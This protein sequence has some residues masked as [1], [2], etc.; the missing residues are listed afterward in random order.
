MFVLGAL[1][2]MQKETV[3]P[4]KKGLISTR[5][6]IVVSLGLA[7]VKGTA[8]V[9][10]NSYALVADAIES[11]SDVFSSVVLWFALKVAAKPPDQNHPY[12]HGKAEPLA[13]MVVGIALLGAAALIIV[14]S[15]RHLTTPHEAP[16]P[17]TLGVLLIVIVIK[18][19]L[20]RYVG[21][22]GEE[23]ESGAVKADAFHHRSDAITSG[24]AFVGISVALVGGEGYE[25]ADDWAALFAAGVILYN[26]Y[27]IVRPALSEVMDEA[28][29]EEVLEKV[30]EIAISVQGVASLDKCFVRK[31]GFEYYVDLH[32]VVDG[33]LSV[34]EGHRIAHEVKDAILQQHARISDVLIHI[35][36][37]TYDKA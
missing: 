23:T 25:G 27:H 35:E 16:A 34:R 28:P 7:L 37:D 32:V 20:F 15:I 8:G 22:I 30:K 10:G 36:P 3:H 29:S 14:E 33:D 5:L 6:G 26:A 11:L 17:F 12:G 13:T 2:I 4:A 19:V 31:M 21:K 1:S 18:E 9:L 24:A